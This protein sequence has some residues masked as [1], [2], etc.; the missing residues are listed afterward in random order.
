MR[1]KEG[2]NDVQKR[3]GW[4]LK[5]ELEEEAQ[6]WGS[7]DGSYSALHVIQITMTGLVVSTYR[8][9]PTVTSAKSEYMYA[10]I[11]QMSPCCQQSNS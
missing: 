7:A 4:W 10:C 8:I 9:G 3:R 1:G 5:G 6:V 2:R 11:I